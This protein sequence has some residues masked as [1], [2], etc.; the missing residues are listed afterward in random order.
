M[1]C[2][3]KFL[4]LGDTSMYIQCRGVSA[5]SLKIC[6]RRHSL[7]PITGNIWIFIIIHV[8]ILCNTTPFH[9]RSTYLC[10]NFDVTG[11]MCVGDTQ[12]THKL[13]TR[14]AVIR[15]QFVV[16]TSTLIQCDIISCCYGDDVVMFEG[17]DR[18]MTSRA[19]LTELTSTIQTETGRWDVLITVSETTNT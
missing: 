11:M 3:M 12:T 19:R 10:Y 6:K 18:D 5:V 4:E 15:Q 14:Q 8:D 2:Q 9:V 1:A 16:M 13:M 17:W 7:F